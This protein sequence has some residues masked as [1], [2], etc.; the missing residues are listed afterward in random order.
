[1]ARRSTPQ[2]ANEPAPRPPAPPGGRT[3]DIVDAALRLLETEGPEAVTMRR[4]ASELGIRAPSLYK[5]VPDKGA[6]EGLLQQHAMRAF[7]EA[8]GAVGDD[9]RSIAAAYRT[10]AVQNPHLYE[11]VARRPVR[12]DIVGDVEQFAGAPL[13]RAVGGDATRARA[14]L[15]LAHGLVDLELNDH[16]PPDADL[17]AVW[18]T[19]LDALTSVKRP[20][21][22]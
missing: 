12:R 21:R 3:R 16:F 1:M 22:R 17:R 5:H 4:V 9:P 14:F 2:P 6:I 18:D 11:L 10:W 15:G 20:R 13:L 8:V 7:G 19:A